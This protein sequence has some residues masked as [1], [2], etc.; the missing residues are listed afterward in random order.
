MAACYAIVFAPSFHHVGAHF[1]DA[2]GHE[3]V[4]GTLQLVRDE[5]VV[6]SGLAKHVQELRRFDSREDA[7]LWH[8]AVRL[9][10]ME[11]RGKPT[12]TARPPR[13]GGDAARAPF[14]Q[15]VQV[16]ILEP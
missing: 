8:K 7:R 4:G 2:D 14:I 5:R 11:G 12:G 15:G 6:W 1:V 16:R 10:L 3:Q 9:E 13:A